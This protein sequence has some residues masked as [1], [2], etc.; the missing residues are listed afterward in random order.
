M[1]RHVTVSVAIA[2]SLAAGLAAQGGQA[3][4]SVPEGAAPAS[5]QCRSSFVK[6]GSFFKGTTYRSHADFSGMSRDTVFEKA[7]QSLAADGW[8]I[9]NT[10]KDIGL[11]TALQQAVDGGRNTPLNTVVKQQGADSVRVEMSFSLGAMMKAPDDSVRDDFCKVLN[12]V[13]QGLE[14]AKRDPASVPQ[15]ATGERPVAGQSHHEE[16]SPR[17]MPAAVEAPAPQKT[18]PASEQCRSSF[19]KEGSFL[20]G[21]TYRSHADFSGMSRDTV[22]EKA[23]QSLAADGWQITNTNKDIGLITALQQA[24][25][26]GRNTPLN[27]VLK[28][29]GADIVRV[30]MSFAL[31]AMMKA[32]DDSVRDDFC[33]VLSGI[34]P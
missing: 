25:G 18:A 7:A 14:D 4:T 33:K 24:V 10:N 34:G 13:T 1:R 8:Q 32:P 22:F 11:I 17:A 19:A 23:A 28:Q 3:A 21:T 27:V 6:E 30:E 2:V 20:K 29:Q 15:G 5:E 12:G 26:G 16:S 31:G 9:T